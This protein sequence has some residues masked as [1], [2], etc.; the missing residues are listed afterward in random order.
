MV[1]GL[2]LVIVAFGTSYVQSTQRRAVV[3]SDRA[4]LRTAPDPAAVS[5][6]TLSEGT[7]LAVR[8]RRTQW[9]EVRLADGTRGWVPSRALGDV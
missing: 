6:T 7:L 8:A 5:D 4:P 3:V 2:L 1:A 9:T